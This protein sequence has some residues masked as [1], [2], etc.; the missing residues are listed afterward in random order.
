MSGKKTAKKFFG[1]LAFVI[2]VVLFII[3][4]VRYYVP[5]S[6]E[7]V[8]A[9]VLNNVIHKG[10]IFKT[11]EGE[12][13]QSGFRPRQQGLQSNDFNFSV[14]DASLAKRLMDMSGQE[15]RLHYKEYYGTLPW[16]GYSKFIVDSVL[17]VQPYNS[18]DEPQVTG[19]M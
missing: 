7:G 11:Y 6:D 2:V 5:L 8:K 4:Y 16:R 14:E 15:V 1:I 10:V 19:G 3:M 17:D 13:I 9:G 18:T 12:L